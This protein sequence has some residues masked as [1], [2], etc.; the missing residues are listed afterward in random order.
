VVDFGIN[1]ADSLG[2][3]TRDQVQWLNKTGD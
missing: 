2:S 3:G 1:G